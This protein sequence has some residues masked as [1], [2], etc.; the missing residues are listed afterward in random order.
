M[1][2]MNN[3]MKRLAAHYETLRGK[4]PEDRVLIVF[5]IDGTIL[6]MRYVVLHVLRAVDRERGTDHFSDLKAS[7]IDVH[8]DRVRDLLKGMNISDEVR[9]EIMARYERLL[10]SSTAVLESHRPFGGVM[11]VMRWFQ[12]QR[13]TFVALNTGRPESLRFNTLRALNALGREYQVRFQHDLL[14]MKREGWKADVP[15]AKAA[16]IEHFRAAGYRICAFVDHE[17]DNLLAVSKIDP[18]H[19]ILL[20]H[21]DTIFNSNED[22]LP[23][24]A[25]TG[26]G[27]DIASLVSEKT[28]PR[29][30]QLVWSC[31]GNRERFLRFLE[32]G[33]AWVGLGPYS[34]P[35][36]REMGRRPG[37][38]IAEDECL[39]LIKGRGK[40]LKIDL[41]ESGFFAGDAIRIIRDHGFEDSDVW[42]AAESAALSEV[43]FRILRDL[44]PSAIIECPIDS[45]APALLQT[46]R[47]AREALVRLADWGIN[48][49]SID[50]RTPGQRR[51]LHLLKR[52]DFETGVNHPGDLESF[53]QAVLLMPH[54]VTS[55]FSFA[56][57][58]EGKM[59]GK[60]RDDQ[61]PDGLVRTA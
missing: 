35:F 24:R 5:D 30:V 34:F 25:V 22:D 11:D 49:F 19:E 13:N 52:W 6:D 59:T 60:E 48:R 15:D 39:S 51:I 23:E 17:P 45:L 42:F 43:G 53:L 37:Q 20:L 26:Q 27:Y 61:R 32:T 21:A 41:G 44:Y 28:L 31:R 8:E 57:W 55:D 7:D 3:W 9:D 38:D 10:F 46:P 33:I 16:G 36:H 54:S 56:R 4:Y 29:H 40:K 14:Y 12:M 50:W 47:W 18:G 2:I 58:Y 1:K